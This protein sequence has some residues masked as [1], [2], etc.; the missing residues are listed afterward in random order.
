MKS[1]IVYGPK[2]CGKT[3]HA[4]E[5]LRRHGLRR[6]VEVESEPRK[7]NLRPQEEGVLYLTNDEQTAHHDGQRFGIRVMS[8]EDAMRTIS[9]PEGVEFT[10]VNRTKHDWAE[11]ARTYAEGCGRPFSPGE[12]ERQYQQQPSPTFQAFDQFAGAM[13]R[14]LEKHR[15]LKGDGWQ[16]ASLETLQNLLAAELDKPQIDMVDVANYAMMLWGL[17]NTHPGYVERKVQF[18]PAFAA[19]YGGR[20]NKEA[21]HDVYTATAEAVLRQSQTRCPECLGG[22][23]HEE[24]CPRATDRLE[25][26]LKLIETREELA[27]WLLNQTANFSREYVESLTTA[28][29]VG[30]A[31]HNRLAPGPWCDLK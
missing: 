28:D 18:N 26:T 9:E 5:L 20:Y 2:G 10:G 27:N 31:K 24:N 21:P 3:T 14:K 4:K 7:R 8:F 17:T 11:L 1:L 30:L 23:V 13:A 16:R 6:A 29:L 12:F 22:S 25:Y 19:P 15:M